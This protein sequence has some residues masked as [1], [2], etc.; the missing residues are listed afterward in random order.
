M[1][2]AELIIK[3][4]IEIEELKQ[5]IGYLKDCAKEAISELSYCEQW[6]INAK[7]FP[8]VAMGCIVR[9]RRSLVD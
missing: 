9:A 8:S 4:Q 5:E 6:S 7:G 3:Q 1:N 2:R